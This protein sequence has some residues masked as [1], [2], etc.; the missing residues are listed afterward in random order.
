MLGVE[1]YPLPEETILISSTE[2]S[3][4]EATA[5][6]LIPQDVPGASIIILG[7]VV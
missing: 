6:A 2:P 1:V 4:I 3:L 5:V 7:G